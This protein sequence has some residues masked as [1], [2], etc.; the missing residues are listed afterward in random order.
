MNEILLYLKAGGERFDMEI[1]EATGIP[2]AMVRCYLSELTA[3][4]D[5]VAC[6]K[7]KFDQGEKIEGISC[8]LAVYIPQRKLS[9]KS[10]EQ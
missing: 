10:K 1:A 3:K 8:R 4:G 9:M 6:H 2:L 7:I 5:I